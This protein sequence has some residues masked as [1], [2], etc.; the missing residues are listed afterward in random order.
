MEPC[1]EASKDIPCGASERLS[2]EAL[3]LQQARRQRKEQAKAAKMLHKMSVKGS[4][5]EKHTA[6]GVTVMRTLVPPD[7]CRIA[8]HPQQRKECVTCTVEPI[9][10]TIASSDGCANP[11][12]GMDHEKAPQQWIVTSVVRHMNDDHLDWF[13]RRSSLRDLGRDMFPNVKEISESVS[14]YRMVIDYMDKLALD[15]GSEMPSTSSPVRR[16]DRFD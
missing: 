16:R 8:K 2:D 1:P 7:N 11:E 13:W 9:V 3:S 15:I 6:K 12:G 10:S 5:L 14:A 4:P